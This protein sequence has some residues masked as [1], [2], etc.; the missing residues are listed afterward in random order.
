M[1]N[2]LRLLPSKRTASITTVA[3]LLSVA[4]LFC[5]LTAAMSDVGESKAF[6]YSVLRFW[7]FFVATDD[8]AENVLQQGSEHPFHV[9]S[10]N[11]DKLADRVRNATEGTEFVFDGDVTLNSSIEVCTSNLHFRGAPGKVPRITCAAEE[12][13]FVV[14]YELKLMRQERK[15]VYILVSTL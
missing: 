2:Q 6:G 15:A 8:S 4:N 9:S 5:T 12:P 11:V 13:G 10:N 3:L 1:K 7:L 14:R